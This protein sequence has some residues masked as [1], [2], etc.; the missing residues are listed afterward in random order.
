MTAGNHVL[1]RI[2]QSLDEATKE[3]NGLTLS[4]MATISLEGRPRVRGVIL[5]QFRSAPERLYFATHI[6]AAKIAEIRRTPQVALTGNDAEYAVQLRL[7]GRAN[8]IDD[9]AQRQQA[10]ESLAPHSQDVYASPHVP[11]TPVDE[12]LD[13][14]AGDQKSA[15]ERFAWV[16]IELDRIDWLDLAAVPDQR[17]QFSRDTVSWRGQRIVP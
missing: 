2:W 14:P 9:Q 7:E 6:R 15:F 1:Q 8:I 4:F 17:W 10:W 16:E 13:E 5:R 11:E 12:M 3:N